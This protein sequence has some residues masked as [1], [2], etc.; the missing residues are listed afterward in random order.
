M[1]DRE[2]VINAIECCIDGCLCAECDY[3]GIEG[4][5]NKVLLTDALALLKE[6]EDLGTELTNA[7]E[8]IHKKNERIEKLL[9]EQEKQKFFVDESGKITPLPVVVRCKDCKWFHQAFKSEGRC[10]KH[11]D[12]FHEPNWFC[13]DGERK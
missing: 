6:Q 3:E 11:D 12:D 7:V 9:K 1:P 13:A 8:L 5:W 2:K 4:C 10:I